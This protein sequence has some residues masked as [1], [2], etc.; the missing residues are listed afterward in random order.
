MK[1]KSLLYFI[2]ATAI[3][4]L[5]ILTIILSFSN[6]YEQFGYVLP[7]LYITIFPLAL[8]WLAWYFNHHGFALA[9]L[10]LLIMII[11]N[12]FGFAQ[13]LNSQSIEYFV[14]SRFAPIVRTSYLTSTLILGI[15]I[16]FTGYEYFNQTKEK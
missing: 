10:L 16:I 5:F 15:T 12:Q 7:R 13:V 2:S 8:I 9:S 14:P 3:T 6:W 11:G 4:L 1:E